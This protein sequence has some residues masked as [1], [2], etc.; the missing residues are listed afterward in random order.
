[1]VSASM[2]VN[3]T[4]VEVII[5]GRTGSADTKALAATE[6]RRFLPGLLTVFV[7]SGSQAGRSRSKNMP[8]LQGKTMIDGRAAAYVCIGSSCR[9][10]VTDPADLEVL[11]DGI[12][13]SSKQ[14]MKGVK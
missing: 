3:G 13:K 8:I 9:K 5:A 11:L 7:D 2:A 12:S 4:P 6:R 14:N 1:M 10:P